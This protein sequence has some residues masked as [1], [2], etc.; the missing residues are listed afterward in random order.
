MM[1]FA[2]YGAKGPHVQAGIMI[3]FLLKMMGFV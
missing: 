1:N 3:K 2:G